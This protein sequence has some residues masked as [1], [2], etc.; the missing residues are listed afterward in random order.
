[1]EKMTTQALENHVFRVEFMLLEFIRRPNPE[2]TLDYNP[3]WIDSNY[4][5][6][7]ENSTRARDRVEKWIISKSTLMTVVTLLNNRK[8]NLKE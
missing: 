5:P 6:L 4:R 7:E 2:A 8:L 1:M 3:N